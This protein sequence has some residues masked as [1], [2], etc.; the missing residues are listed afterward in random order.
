MHI[1]TQLSEQKTVEISISSVYCTNFNFLDF[2][3]FMK[4][5]T[6]GGSLL[7][8]YAAAAA[9]AAKSLQSCPTLWDP[10]DGSSPGS[11][12]PGIL[13]AR[14]LEW[15]AISFSNAW[16][17]KVKVKSLSRVQLFATPWTEAHQAPPSM[18]FSRQEYWVGCHCLLQKIHCTSL[19]IFFITPNL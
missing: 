18:G 17:W 3:I 13:Q 6:I 15:V 2:I 9:A 19:Y 5:V 16:K 10:M 7:K 8:I 4:D 12:V 11:A 14:T 1:Y